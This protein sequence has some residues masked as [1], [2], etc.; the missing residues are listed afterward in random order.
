MLV[1]V[2]VDTVD[3]Y[4]QFVKQCTAHVTCNRMLNTGN[5]ERWQ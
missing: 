5:D 1:Y 2:Y 4:G 3:A